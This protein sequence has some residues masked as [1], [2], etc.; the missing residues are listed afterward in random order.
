MPTV[1]LSPVGNDEQYF[2]KQGVVAGGGFKLFTY[3][4]GSVNTPTATYTDITGATPNANPIILDSAGHPPQEIWIPNGVQ[5]KFVLQDQTGVVQWT[6]DFIPGI[7]DPFSLTGVSAAMT[8]VVTAPTV[9]AAR[10]L[11]GIP[12]QNLLIG[13]MQVWQRG[14]AFTNPTFGGS[15]YCCDRWGFNR[16]G[17]VSG[18]TVSR[19]AFGSSQ[20]PTYGVIWQRTAGD[21]STASMAATHALE[22]IDA[23]QLRGQTVTFSILA[24]KGL[25]YSGSILGLVIFYGTGTDQRLQNF[26][27]LTPV[28]SGS[29]V[30]TGTPTTYSISAA[31]PAGATEV[32]LQIAWIPSGTAGVSDLVLLGQP[33][34]EIGSVATPFVAR[35][36]AQEL[37]LCQRYYEKSFPYGT[38]PVQGVGSLAGASYFA[39]VAAG[40][41][42]QAAPGVSFKVTK[43]TSSYTPTIYNPISVNAQIRNSS[44]ALDWTATSIQTASDGGFQVFGTGAVGSSAGAT[45]IF[46]WSADAEL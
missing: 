28:G 26:T 37:A 41:I 8:P 6:K 7:N 5:V 9:D 30:L 34:L 44:N 42:A 10:S 40:A 17:D 29:V 33:K 39:Q 12:G 38:T 3:V 22:S 23:T 32:G 18:S 31:I 20:Q 14:T 19:F 15:Y 2:T 46:H 24:A 13:D 45:S 43:R 11:L 1:S 36:F 4:A 16:N 35:P 25:N 21:V 27:G